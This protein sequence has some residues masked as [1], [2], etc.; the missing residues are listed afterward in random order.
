MSLVQ[1]LVVGSVECFADIVYRYLCSPLVTVP[2]ARM[3][4]VMTKRFIFH[5]PELL[6]LD[7]SYF[8]FFSAPF[9]VTVLSNGTVTSINKKIVS[10][11]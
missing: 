1:L 4:T 8:S 5:S 7:F 11:V 9:Y 6:Y 2:V 10:S 3:I